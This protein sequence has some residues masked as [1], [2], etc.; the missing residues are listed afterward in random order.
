MMHQRDGG[1]VLAMEKDIKERQK[2]YFHKHFNE[3]HKYSL[4][5]N[6]LNTIKD[7]KLPILL[8]KNPR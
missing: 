1:K 5:L 3:R 2:S 6:V 4:N 7:D 8:S